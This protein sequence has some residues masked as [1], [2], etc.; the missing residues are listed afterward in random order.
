MSACLFSAVLCPPFQKFL[1]I[2]QERI[3]SKTSKRQR[4]M[5][6]SKTSKRQRASERDVGDLKHAVLGSGG[7]AREK[8][9]QGQGRGI[10]LCNVRYGGNIEES[11][12]NMCG[13]QVGGRGRER[14]RERVSDV[15]E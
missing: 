3:Y 14:E 15:R 8:G 1:K 4:A 11:M 13:K 7:A 12:E 2:Q 10:G 9:S 6:Y 5:T